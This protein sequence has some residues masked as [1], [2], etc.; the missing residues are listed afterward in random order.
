MTSWLWLAALAAMAITTADAQSRFDVY[1]LAI[2]SQD[3]IEV[4]APTHAFPSIDGVRKSARA[5]ADVFANA[6]S[7]YGVLL[8]SGENQLIGVSDVYSAL[9]KINAKLRSDRPANPLIVYYFAGH[10]ISEGI[11][12]NHFSVPGNLAYRGALSDLDL[13]V[14][15]DAAIYTADLVDRLEKTKL[16]FLVILDNCYE[17]KARNFNS[18]VLSKPAQQSLTQS[19]NVLKFM[20]EFHDT[21]PVLF[22]TEPGTTVTTAP[23]PRDPSP[24]VTGVAP[25]ARRILIMRKQSPNQVRLGDFISRMTSAQLDGTTKA[26]VTH[27][28]PVKSGDAIIWSS[29]LPKGTHAEIV[30]T[31]SKPVILGRTGTAAVTT[32]KTPSAPKIA[33]GTIS[34]SGPPGEFISDG[35]SYAFAGNKVRIEI[36]QNTPGE[37]DIEVPDDA[38]SWG[39]SF[40]TGGGRAFEKKTY[41]AAQRLSNA[42]HPGLE[43]TAPGRGCNETHGEYSVD[44][45]AF[46]AQRNV[47]RFSA[48]FRQLC[49][50]QRQPLT[51]AINISVR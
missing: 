7:R 27:S 40:A 51:G 18:P 16:P 3:Y 14:I 43:V 21:Y 24:Q 45:V 23:D 36:T 5:V 47:T 33:S 29:N 46:D 34:I 25:L 17:G 26:A 35:K 19:A 13:Q 48:R 6:G 31:A 38:G 4:P 1:Y 9:D 50:D 2:G 22:S 39:F 41:G 30:G 12:W 44:D 20:N 49:D 28:A 8:V 37:L 32:P 15:G 10:G 11:S 42:N